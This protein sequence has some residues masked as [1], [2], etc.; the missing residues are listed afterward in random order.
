MAKQERAARTRETL[1][2]SAAEVFAEEGFVT[3]S[4]ATISKRAGVSAGGLHFH[5]ESKAA[6][7]EAVEDRAVEALRRITVGRPRPRPRPHDGP[8]AAGAAAVA[9]AGGAGGAAGVAGAAGNWLQVLVDSTHELMALLAEDIVVRAG[10]GLCADASR[11]SGVDLR[12]QW[13]LWVDEVLRSA[14]REGALAEGV[15]ARDAASAVVASTVGLE[16]LGA[17]ERDWVSRQTLTRFWTLMLPRLAAR[18]VL[19]DLVA[20]GTGGSGEPGGTS[21]RVARGAVTGGGTG[22][23]AGR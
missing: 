5:F 21:G 15:S 10:F 12:R 11:G 6:L 20:E 4:I 9:G 18:E 3:A 19:G 8:A 14:A 16:V 1:V 23:G 2:R 22:A 17:G 13:Q 7:A